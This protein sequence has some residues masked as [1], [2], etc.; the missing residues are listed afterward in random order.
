MTN[1]EWNTYLTDARTCSCGRIHRCNMNDIIIEESALKKVPELIHAGTYQAICVVCDSNTNLAAGIALDQILSAASIAYQKIVLPADGLLPDET[2]IG[3]VMT[4]LL[5]RC[6]LII[7]VGSG[8]INDL[9]RFVSYKLGIDY[10]IVCTAPSMDGYT[11]NVA[12]MITKHTKTTY[13]AHMPT[14]LIGDLTILSAAPM[15]LISAGVGDILGK[16]VCLTDW[17]IAHMITNEYFCDYVE[18]LIRQSLKKVK[19]AAS[20]ILSRDTSSIAELMDALVL[21][22]IAMSYIGNSRP[23]S[24][25]EHHLSH[26]WE[27][28]FL[29]AGSHGAWH[30]TKVGI[31][32]IVCIHL[33]QMLNQSLSNFENPTISIFHEADWSIR[34]MDVYGPAAASVIALEKECHKNGSLLVSQRLEALKE[35]KKE[36]SA[37]I[38]T[39]PSADEISNILELL[40]APVTPSAIQVSKE[41]FIQSICY[42]KELRNRFGLL[43]ILFD[44]DLALSF[45]NDLAEFFYID[46]N[47]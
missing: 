46:R 3:M 11:S 36:V 37:I 42:A 22:G 18:S 40:N 33:Y 43:Q 2:G 4:E 29:Q 6:D 12:A 41:M 13:E 21:S 24:G 39:L 45:A 35:H 44:T 30:G 19:S 5:P 14:A 47:N 31:G 26:F 15:D 23:A 9:C 34:M 1:H 32:T 27:M 28:M 38:A 8:T 16:Y 20:G 17:K 10:F 7:A 25:S